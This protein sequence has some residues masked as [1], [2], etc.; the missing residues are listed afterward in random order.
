MTG[1]GAE[2]EPWVALAVAVAVVIGVFRLVLWQRAAP[3]DAKS[4]RWRL[5]LLILLQLAAGGLLFLM[6]FPPSVTTRIGTIVVATEGAPSSIALA[7]GEVLVALPEA[8]TIEG[9]ARVP[10]LATALRRHPSAAQLR[11]EG[12]GLVPRDQSPVGLPVDFDPPPRPRGLID[13]ALPDLVAPGAIFSVGGQVGTLANGVVELVDPANAVVDRETVTRGQRFVLSADTRT[14]GLA[15]FAVRLRDASGALM[16]QVAVPVETVAQ[17]Q[18]RVLVLAGAPGAET[19]Y[20]ARWAE[21]AGIDLDVDIDLGAGVRVGAPVPITAAA[22]AD[23]DLVVID[24]RRWATLSSGQ[25]AALATAASGGLGVLLRPTG[26][27]P[28]STRRS[29]AALGISVSGGDDS[30][31]LRLGAT[32]ALPR[33]DVSADTG[34]PVTPDAEPKAETLPELAR[35]NLAHEGPSAISFLRD[36][37]GIALASWRARGRGRIGLWTVT[38]SYALVLTGR[39]DRYGEMWSELFSALARPD[40]GGRLRQD[41]FARAGQRVVLCGVSGEAN[42]MDPGGHQKALLVDPSAGDRACA[43]YW[44]ERGG[45]HL[46]R[47]G[48]TRET[49]I[50]VHPGDAA[51]S[52]IKA[53][54]RE[55][56]LALAALP[57]GP[58]SGVEAPRVPGSSW[59]WFAALIAVLTSLWWLERNRRPS[60]T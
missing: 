8:G 37:D 31:P 49:A 36:A 28:E 21:D 3:N 12:E 46:A 50:Y 40:D 23:T 60:R 7:A 51:P 27:L 17:P 52:L 35:R 4:P 22:L 19:K 43:A 25:R 10:D 5:A 45:W 34:A 38:D 2:L 15:L 47:D 56:T 9:A 11:I 32:A 39:P 33:P 44:P 42:V 48:R 30:R 41:G 54:N 13:L 59:P 16:E 20:L 18:P 55:A 6:L 57:T 24:D 58:R 53:T 14:P 1:S 26:P 29:W